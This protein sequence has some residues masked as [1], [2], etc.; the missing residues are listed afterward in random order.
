MALG[1]TCFNF[2]QITR[3]IKEPK[4]DAY[5]GADG[6]KNFL[7]ASKGYDVWKSDPWANGGDPGVRGAIFEIHCGSVQSCIT[8]N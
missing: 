6:E 5:I 2:F 1:W 4:C 3:N 7:L 8:L